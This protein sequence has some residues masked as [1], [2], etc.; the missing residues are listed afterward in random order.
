MQSTKRSSKTKKRS[1]I[2]SK[3]SL[4]FL[5]PLIAV[6]SIFVAGWI[7]FSTPYTTDTKNKDKIKKTQKKSQVKTSKSSPPKKEARSKI[8]FTFF[9]TLTKTKKPIPAT[10]QKENETLFTYLGLYKQNS[11]QPISNEIVESET[12]KS[13]EEFQFIIQVASFRDKSRAERL[14][15]RLEKKGY[16][17]SIEE[18]DIANKGLWRRI[19]LLTGVTNRESAQKLIEKINFEEKVTAYLKKSIS[20]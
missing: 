13:N 1:L 11:D 6:F 14:R 18:V 7:Y 16:Q 19:I 9:E 2:K 3:L 8:D 4:F 20:P 17:V 10:D 12:Q 15:K 5:F